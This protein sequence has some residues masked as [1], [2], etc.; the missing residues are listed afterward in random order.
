MIK[1]DRHTLEYLL[2]LDKV[3]A[4]TAAEG[5]NAQAGEATKKMLVAEA[6]RRLGPLAPWWLHPEALK[7]ARQHCRD[8]L[9]PRWI[10]PGDRLKPGTALVL[11]VPPH[12]NSGPGTPDS[13]SLSPR[14]LLPAVVLPL[15]WM[16]GGKHSSFLPNSLIQMADQVAEA[17][18]EDRYSLHWLFESQ[19]DARDLPC[20]ADSAFVPL[21]LGLRLAQYAQYAAPDPFTWSTGAWDKNNEVDEVDGISQKLATCVLL[22]GKQFFVPTLNYSQALEEAK[23]YSQDQLQIHALPVEKDL[24]KVL[25]NPLKKLPVPPLPGADRK[26]IVDYYRYQIRVD[27]KEGDKYYLENLLDGSVEHCKHHLS[28]SLRELASQ[29]PVLVSILSKNHGLIYLAYKVFNASRAVILMT[30]KED[31]PYQGAKSYL[32]KWQSQQGMQ[33]HWHEFPELVRGATEVEVEQVFQKVERIYG[34]LRDAGRPVLVDHTPGFRTFSLALM[35]KAPPDVRHVYLTHR[36]VEKSLAV[37]PGT[38]C[39]IDLNRFLEAPT[40]EP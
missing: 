38:E 15:R 39:Y 14:L 6:I 40:E 17:L 33:F 28:G 12:G 25:G 31:D 34:E 21:A 20:S 27:R 32:E 36:T 10:Y 24:N 16:E 7:L 37:D 23:R 35:V 1:L 18:K 29:R 8:L 13:F 26:E 22:R 2:E 30:S 3:Y 9:H 5:T 11:V 4:A 19:L